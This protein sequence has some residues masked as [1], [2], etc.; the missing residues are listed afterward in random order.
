MSQGAFD[1][2]QDDNFSFI[3]EFTGNWPLISGN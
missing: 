3:P 2:A 1:S